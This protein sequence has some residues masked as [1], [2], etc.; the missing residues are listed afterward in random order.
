MARLGSKPKRNRASSQREPATLNGKN[1]TATAGVVGGLFFPQSKRLGI[2]QGSYSP[3]V[4]ERLI[5]AGVH[6]HSFER[7]SAALQHLADLSIPTKQVERLT[8]R[9]GTER[10]DE[11]DA[12][13]AVYQALP[14]ARPKSAL[15]G[16]VKPDLAV[17]EVDG[18][19]LQVLDRVAA[20]AVP[21]GETAASAGHWRED[22]VG[23]LATMTSTVSVVD[24]CPTIPESFID[25]LRIVKLAQ[26]IKGS[27]GVGAAATQEAAATEPATTA[28]TYTAPK[29]QQRSVAATLQDVHGFGAILA[30]AA[31][32]RGFYEAKRRALRGRRFWRRQLGGVGAALLELHADR[33]FHSRFELC[34][35]S[36]DGGT[37][38]CVGLG[39]LHRIGSTLCGRGRW[40]GL[41]PA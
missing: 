29:L 30:Q 5:Y 40:S 25:P 31:W 20:D 19:R 10:R 1:L 28:A 21:R 36:G 33:R 4:L 32:E 11:R 6:H 41:S 26:E 17:V 8:Q 15:A 38:V 16:V 18:G 2:D 9:I 39:G 14:L 35:S 13:V 37:V 27:M 7:A 34:V 22:K 23:L 24:P 3:A 12:A